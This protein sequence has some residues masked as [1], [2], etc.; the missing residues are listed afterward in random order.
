VSP[1][2]GCER[3]QNAEPHDEDA[4]QEPGAPTEAQGHVPLP[5]GHEPA[6]A[7]DD[8]HLLRG[9]DG[10]HRGRRDPM[11]LSPT[12]PHLEKRGGVKAPVRED[13]LDRA[14]APACKRETDTVGEPVASDGARR[15][16]PPALA[17]CNRHPGTG[18]RY[19]AMRNSVS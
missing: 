1:E 11:D 17:L 6:P 13:P 9:D 5:V 14:V 2:L 7:I 15:V 8:E 18:P 12:R 4:A 10:D 16:E 19:P 3:G